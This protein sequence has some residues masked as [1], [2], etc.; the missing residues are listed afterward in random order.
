MYARKQVII[1]HENLYRFFVSVSFAFGYYV[2]LSEEEVDK[3][4]RTEFHLCGLSFAICFLFFFVMSNNYLFIFASFK[5]QHANFYFPLALIFYLSFFYLF[6][7]LLQN[8]KKKMSSVFLVQIYMNIVNFCKLSTLLG[9][10]L[11][12]TV[13]LLFLCLFFNY[14]NNY[15]NI[16]LILMK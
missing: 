14:T 9:R 2:L 11:W 5:F 15:S 7:Y 6:C 8:Q 3:E 16:F 1:K 10:F 12:K 13:N 4:K